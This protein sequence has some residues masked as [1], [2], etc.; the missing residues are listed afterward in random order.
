MEAL[1]LALRSIPDHFDTE[2]LADVDGRLADIVRDHH[3]S[4]G[5]A[6]ESGS[7]AWGFP[8]PDSDYDC[9]F[10]FVRQT[11]DYLSPWQ[12]R[13]VIE[14]P[15]END[16]D[17][18]GWELGK[19]IK[20]L[21]KGN[22]VVI[23]W[24]MSPI[25]Y[26]GDP[27]FRDGLIRLATNHTDRASIGR[28]YLHLGERQRNTY[29]ADHKTVSLKKIFYALRPAAALRWLRGHPDAVIPPMDFATLLEQCDPPAEI[30][31]LSLELI[32]QKAVTRE[33]GAGPLPKPIR[34]FIDAE[35]EAARTHFSTRA[36]R[37][38]EEARTDA[39]AFF[40]STLDD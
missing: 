32:A 26:A 18:N 5:L 21:L 29:F 35:F 15:L 23:E 1:P 34:T 8:S 19:A 16:M 27:G 3:V 31:R 7:R 12:K 38:S 22:A 24:L 6:I 40:R 39:E 36:H 11:A 2:R 28:H 37:L 25:V 17:L 4:I 33:L 20:L 14:T 9:R 10:L 13:D 30:V